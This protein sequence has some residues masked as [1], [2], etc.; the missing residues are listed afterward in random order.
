M[1]NTIGDHHIDDVERPKKGQVY[2]RQAKLGR[3]GLTAQAVM[4]WRKKPSGYEP[5]PVKVSHRPEASLA[6]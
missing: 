4:K 2:V 3:L 1:R 6:W 5:R